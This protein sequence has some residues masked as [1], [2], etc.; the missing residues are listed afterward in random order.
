MKHPRG[1]S[2]SNAGNVDSLE[3]HVTGKRPIRTFRR[4]SS[5]ALTRIGAV[6]HASW[7]TARSSCPASGTCAARLRTDDTEASSTRFACVG[8]P[9]RSAQDSLGHPGVRGPKGLRRRHRAA[10]AVV[11][12][13]PTTVASHGNLTNEPG[14]SRRRRSPP[15][16]ARRSRPD[17]R[18]HGGSLQADVGSFSVTR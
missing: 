16:G 12:M 3:A 1:D 5:L 2:S 7:F 10:E 4:L 15:V 14:T 8:R 6:A 9:D 13:R 18:W 11:P 17:C